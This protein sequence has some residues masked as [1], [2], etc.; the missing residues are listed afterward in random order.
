MSDS[1]TT[2][3]LVVAYSLIGVAYGWVWLHLP[4][5]HPFDVVLLPPVTFAIVGGLIGVVV[6]KVI[7]WWRRSRANR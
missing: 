4:G 7:I 1:E 6:A 3:R 5:R 2:L